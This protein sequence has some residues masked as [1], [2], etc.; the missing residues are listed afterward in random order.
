MIR[1]SMDID[2][3]TVPG[4]IDVHMHGIVARMYPYVGDVSEGGW[5]T[6]SVKWSRTFPIY[7]GPTPHRE[8]IRIEAEKSPVLRLMLGKKVGLIGG[9]IEGAFS[10]LRE[11]SGRKDFDISGRLL[12]IDDTKNQYI[13][14]QNFTRSHFDD[15]PTYGPSV[16]IEPPPEDH[17]EESSSTICACWLVTRE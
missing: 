13:A 4:D 12:Y 10:V 2:L 17:V 15:W 7:V 3:S 6:Y 8:G 1:Y 11:L 14:M 16:T 5:P 9:V